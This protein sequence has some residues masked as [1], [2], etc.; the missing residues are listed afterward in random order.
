MFPNIQIGVTRPVCVVINA[1]V[2]HHC[3]HSVNLGLIGE[4]SQAEFGTEID[5][6]LARRILPRVSFGSILWDEAIVVHL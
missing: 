1:I 6:A 3:N 5:F 2:V 4:C